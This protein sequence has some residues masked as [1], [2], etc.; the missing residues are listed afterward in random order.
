MSK[1]SSKKTENHL[2]SEIHLRLKELS[3]SN[4]VPAE[5]ISENNPEYEKIVK[6][7]NESIR[8]CLAETDDFYNNLKDEVDNKIYADQTFGPIRANL[9]ANSVLLEKVV[10]SLQNVK[11]KMKACNKFV[12]LGNEVVERNE[13]SEL[14]DSQEDKEN[15]DMN[16][17]SLPPT[18][19]P[20]DAKEI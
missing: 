12:S 7:L 10:G 5:Q 8:R 14:Y 4:S 6:D 11:E 15:V 1:K 16:I 18:K 17:A 3:E 13:D 9:Q 19:K 20:N 2:V